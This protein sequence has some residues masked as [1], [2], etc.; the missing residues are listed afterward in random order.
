MGAAPLRPGLRGGCARRSRHRRHGRRP[1]PGWR[2]ETP[3]RHGNAPG[4][5]R[6]PRQGGRR[7]DLWRGPCRRT[8]WRPRRHR[9]GRDRPV[10]VQPAPR[11]PAPFAGPHPVPA[12]HGLRDHPGSGTSAPRPPDAPLR[13]RGRQAPGPGLW[14]DLRT[15]HSRHRGG[16]DPGGAGLRR[17]HRRSRNPGA[18]RRPSDRR[19]L[20]PAGRTGPGRTTPRLALSSCRSS[21]RGRPGRHGPARAGPSSTD[22]TVAGQDRD[23]LARIRHRADD[24]DGLHR[25]T[26]GLAAEPLQP[27]G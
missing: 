20:H 11:R 18:L 7:S 26:A 24:A 13:A 6:R 17:T 1:S 27:D 14:P 10:S 21:H 3:G 2:G 23:R 8:S 5:S 16:A 9:R 25:R 12:P 15:H 4:G 22:P 19:A